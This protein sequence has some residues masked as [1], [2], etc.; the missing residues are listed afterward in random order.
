MIETYA[1]L[2]ALS[3]IFA[4]IAAYFSINSWIR[5][6]ES[7]F[8]TIKAKV[9]LDKSFLDYN[10]KLS[11]AVVWIVGGLI[12]LHSIMEYIEINGSIPAGF[13]N[14]YYGALPVAMLSLVLVTYL[15]FRLLSKHSKKLS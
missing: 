7:D 11:L 9:F 14:V 1:I 8:D 12:S 6:K 10:F 5:W 3:L 4:F 15:W 2:V 13:Y